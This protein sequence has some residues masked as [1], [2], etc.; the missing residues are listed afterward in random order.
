MC[1]VV[2]GDMPNDCCALQ[3][4]AAGINGAPSIHTTLAKDEVIGS[5]IT[6]VEAQMALD[7]KTTALKYLQGLIW[8]GGFRKGDLKGQLF[9]DVPDVL[10]QLRDLGIKSYIYSS[11]SRQAQRD[12]FGHTQV[13]RHLLVRDECG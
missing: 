1:A 8:T 7:R 13:Q 10:Q 12:L 4:V 11:G 6:Y 9:R 3:D 2:G 5:C